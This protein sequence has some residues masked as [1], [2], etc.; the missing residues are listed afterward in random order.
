MESLVDAKDEVVESIESMERRHNLQR[1]ELADFNKRALKS[2]KKSQ[3]VVVEAE[4]LQR[5]FDL[6]ARQTEEMD[7]LTELIDSGGV[8]CIIH[9]LNVIINFDL[10][11]VSQL[12]SVER[13]SVEV[14][15]VELD[16]LEASETDKVA[17]KKAKAQRKRVSKCF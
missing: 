14:M 8:L 1:S 6:K 11:G 7:A 17:S 16:T 15:A 3:K 2:A 9:R 12:K 10:S 13:D 4:C 5:E